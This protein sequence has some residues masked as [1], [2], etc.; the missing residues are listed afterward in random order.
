MSDKRRCFRCDFI[1]GFKFHK[2]VFDERI[3]LHRKCTKSEITKSIKSETSKMF[4]QMRELPASRFTARY[5]QMRE[6]LELRIV[7]THNRLTLNLQRDFM[8]SQE[9]RISF[10][11]Q[12]VIRELGREI[13]REG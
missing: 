6:S 13:P 10:M 9:R 12:A 5:R 11:R 2:A 1:E 4:S 8:V 3:A 7:E